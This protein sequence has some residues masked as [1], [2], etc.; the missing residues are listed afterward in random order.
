MKVTKENYRLGIDMG[1]T[2]I[3]WCML[4]LDSNDNPI[5]IIKMG[6][7]I[8]PDGRDDKTKEPLSVKRRNYRSIRKN[9]DRYLL[10]RE[11]LLNCLD[12]HSLLPQNE[13][14]RTSL[15]MQDP[16][17]IRH[18]AL[19]KEITLYEISRAFI[20]L[21]K[22]RGFKSNRKENAQEKGTKISDAIS[23]LQHKLTETK[24]RTIGEYL[25]NIN[26]KVNLN[27]QHHKKPTKFRYESDIADEKIFPTREMIE[28]EFNTLW[29]TQ[30][31]YHKELSDSLKDEIYKVI[32]TQRPLKPTI[33]GKCYLE[34]TEDRIHRAHPFFQEFRLL[35]EINNLELIDITTGE[36]ID[37][38]Q[39]ERNLIFNVMNVCDKKDYPKVRALIRK[40]DTDCYRFNLESEN[41]TKLLGNESYHALKVKLKN[42]YDSLS[43]Q[44]K[45]NIIDILL[46]DDSD[47]EIQIKLHNLGLTSDETNSVFN[48]KLPFSYGNL[49]MKAL[50][51]LISHMKA[52]LNYSEA[53]IEAGYKHS[54]IATEP[55]YCKGDLP[56]YGELLPGSVLP[57]ARISNDVDADLFGKINN[58]TVHIALN[59]V[60]KILNALCSQYGAPKEIVIELARDL[61][62]NEEQ[63]K[64]INKQI[65]KNTKTNERI[66][67]ELAKL[68]IENNGE[69]RLKFKLWEEMSSNPLERCCVYSGNQIT[70]AN[71][72]QPQ[73][74][75][76]HILPKSRTFDDSVSNKILCY[77][78]A[79][80]YKKERSPHEAFGQSHD[81]YSWEMILER[82]HKLPDNKKWRFQVNAMER[83]ADEAVVLGRMLN[84]T[85]YMSR[86][87]KA[88]LSYVC[89][90]NNIWCPAGQ[91]TAKLRR[92]WGLNSILSETNEKERTDH[93]H[94]AI[95]AL[96][97]AFTS[98]S[99]VK[100][101]ADAVRFSDD[102]YI[103]KMPYPWNGFNLDMVKEKVDQIKV[104][105]KPDQPNPSLLATR[106]QTAGAL[107][108]ETALFF[109]HTDTNDSKFAY[110]TSKVDIMSLET[111]KQILEVVSQPIQ[112]VLMD[113]VRKDISKD[114]FKQAV[115]T[116]ATKHNVKKVKTMSKLNPNNLIPIKDKQGNIFKYY[117][118]DENLFI[119]IYNPKP[120]DSKSKWKDLVVNSFKAH[121]SNFTPD[122]KN[123]FP[124]GK[125]IMRL[126]KNDI[127]VFTNEKGKREFKRVRKFSQ[128]R[129]F[130][131]ELNT[132]K[133]EKGSEDIGEKYSANQLLQ[134][135]AAK[136]GIDI[137]GRVFDPKKE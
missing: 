53:C 133:K 122:W 85:R 21:A 54:G 88:Y 120:F 121:K 13:K 51:K 35:Q 66:S 22:R 135:Q 98:R 36:V 59:Q 78:Q 39:E 113:F 46:S 47:E 79:N 48:A 70:A 111:E 130:L 2:S 23:N 69:N 41:K 55:T 75:I 109:H 49:S 43:E 81:G 44:K 64:E 60:R 124:M 90:S 94:H 8:F 38:T 95:D 137:L 83:F 129:I 99:I 87:T 107:M 65:N 92:Y 37:L 20:H 1:S 116:W 26:C 62:L 112:D 118:S 102:R 96:V 16:L 74:Q 105:F 18:R 84:D 50:Q 72:Y 3:G 25:W 29:N 115:K 82:A 15:F 14:E 5:D 61:K 32:F 73:V 86:S 97:I 114:E 31:Q 91:L 108:Q 110:F 40:K 42:I 123:E 119:D 103:G 7:R 104:S 134:M 27:D 9:L 67:L 34:P 106:N 125:L 17:E 89:G 71:L 19:D 117:C 93:R 10:R 45:I 136:A 77:H 131:R 100:K 132:A 52:G 57:L 63:K 76:D 58:P 126:Y 56:Y 101:Y 6:V 80:E 128:G 24:V 127:V 11:Q 68:N 33:K 30:R 4:K 12:A 28:N